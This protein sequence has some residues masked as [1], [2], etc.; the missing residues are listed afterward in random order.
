MSPSPIID[1]MGAHALTSMIPSTI[2]APADA[3]IRTVEHYPAEAKRKP[4]WTP[5]SSHR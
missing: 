5:I 4:D 2:G 1:V 3:Y